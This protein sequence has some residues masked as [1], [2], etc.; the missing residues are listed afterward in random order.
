MTTL[1]VAEA[2]RDFAGALRH[3]T[4]DH[5]LVVL[6]RGRKAVAV[7]LP[8]DVLEVLEDLEDVRAADKAVA[9]HA[10]D[11][12]KAVPWDQVKREAGLA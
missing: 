12:S 8:P 2:T 5:E 6:K 10:K 1:S 3:V 7:M 11:P 4:A 9:E